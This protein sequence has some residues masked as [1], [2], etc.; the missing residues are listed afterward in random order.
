MLNFVPFQGSSSCT[1]V[2][3]THGIFTSHHPISPLVIFYPELRRWYTSTWRGWDCGQFPPHQ[4]NCTHHSGSI[5]WFSAFI[6]ARHNFFLPVSSGWCYNQVM[7]LLA[8]YPHQVLRHNFLLQ[9][10]LTNSNLDVDAGLPT[11]F[12]DFWRLYPSGSDL[13]PPFTGEPYESSADNH[14]PLLLR[15]SITPH[16]HLLDSVEM[17]LEW[18]LT[19]F[20][21]RCGLIPEPRTESNKDKDVRWDL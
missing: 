7:L 11:T 14:Q 20:K 13:R 8:F 15:R 1:T 9:L 21:L 2:V 17:V 10:I 6:L 5:L 19:A 4:R 12:L 18:A 3:L 16:I